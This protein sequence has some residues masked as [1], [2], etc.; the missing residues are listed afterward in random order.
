MRTLM[1]LCALALVVAATNS[2]RG[3]EGGFIDAGGTGLVW[4]P[5]QSSLNGSMLN[6]TASVSFAANYSNIDTN[7]QG[8][9]T[10]YS[11]WRLPTLAELTTAID[12]GTIQ[13][14]NLFM[15]FKAPTGKTKTM[16]F[17][18][19]DNKASKAWAMAI[20]FDDQGHIT[21]RSPVQLSK[22]TIACGGYMVRP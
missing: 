11:D 8:V 22:K 21:A 12:N 16:N 13:S 18:V 10:T 1:A 9:S 14:V 4:S 20:T 15:G 17:W 2:S 5:S 19:A 7:L 3:I 6:W